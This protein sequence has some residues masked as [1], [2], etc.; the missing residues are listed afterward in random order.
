MPRLSNGLRVERV[1]DPQAT[2]AAALLQVDVGSH[3]EPDAWPGLAHLLEHLLFAGSCRFSGAQRLMSWLPAQGGRLNA[4]TLGSSTAYFFECAPSQLA[5]AL[6][7]L[8]DM[9]A[10][11]LLAEDAIRQEIATLDAECQLLGSHQETLCEAALSS[12]FQPHPWQRFQAGNARH[13]GSDIAALRT[14]LQQFHQRYYRAPHMTLWLHGPQSDDELWQLAQHHGGALV[15]EALAR[16]RCPRC[17]VSAARAAPVSAARYRPA[18]QRR[19]APAAVIPAGRGVS[20]R[21][22]AA[23]PAAAGRSRGRADGRAAC[24]RSRR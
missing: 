1:S 5:E 12:A 10:A 20:T 15:S 3:Q 22:D 11:P 14:A 17:A 6:A 8:S 2:R 19:A 21:A 13:F 16:R 18:A 9:L 23:A 24:R 4:T 7:R